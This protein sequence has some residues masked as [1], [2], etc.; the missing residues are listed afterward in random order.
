MEIEFIGFIRETRKL[1]LFVLFPLISRLKIN[2]NDKSTNTPVITDYLEF[3]PEG[4]LK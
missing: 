4:L 3:Y 1:V 2:Y